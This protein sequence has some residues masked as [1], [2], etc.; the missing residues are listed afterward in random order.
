MTSTTLIVGAGQ[1]GSDMA[2]ALRQNGY[3]GRIVLIGEEPAVPYRRPPLSKAFLSGEVDEASL[4]IKTREAYAKHDIELRTDVR[5]AM[6]H[7]SAHA[8]SLADGTQLSYDKLALTT[9]GRARRLDLPGADKP[10]VFYVRTI[11]D[12]RRLREHFNPMQ[13]LVI[14]GGGYIGLEVAAVGIKSGLEVTLVEA[15]PRLLAR[16]TGPELS[17]YYDSVHRRHGVDIR[18]GVG[19]QALEGDQL[20]EAVILQDGTRLP[21]DIVIVGIGLIPNTELAEGCGLAVDNGILVDLYSQTSDPDILAAGDCTNHENGF[22]GRRMR[23]ESV[24]NASE[25]ARVA[26]ATICGKRVPH[27]GVPWFWS[28]QYNL[29]LQMVGLSQGHER[30]VVRGSMATD[31]FAA[32]YLQSGVVIA[33]DAVNRPQDFML[34]KKM[35]A[36]RVQADAAALADESLALKS[37]VP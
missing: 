34:G 4:Y 19:V 22:F 32:F 35:V 24:P 18:L 2:S 9:G 13:R 30:I 11:D 33:V 5:V 16:V 25:Q 15:M 31:S 17:Q 10:N 27:A 1:A 28:D 14:I 7:R 29:K 3:D 23:L 37:L 26:A 20:A 6:I 12:I 21:A 36:A 8:V